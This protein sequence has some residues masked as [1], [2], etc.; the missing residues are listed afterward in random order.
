MGWG[1]T[2]DFDTQAEAI[3]WAEEEAACYP[4]HFGDIADEDVRVPVIEVKRVLWIGRAL[5]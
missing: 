3:A 4:G 2:S 1:G 5:P